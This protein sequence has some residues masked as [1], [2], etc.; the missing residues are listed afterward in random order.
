MLLVKFVHVYHSGR[1]LRCLHKKIKFWTF[2]WC[3]CGFLKKKKKKTCVYSNCQLNM[4]CIYWQTIL[5]SWKGG[6]FGHCPLK[7]RHCIWCQFLCLTL[8]QVQDNGA[9]WLSF[10]FFSPLKLGTSDYT[11]AW[12]TK[13]V[14]WITL[15]Q[16]QIN[17]QN[18]GL[19]MKPVKLERLKVL[20]NVFLVLH[21]SEL[22]NFL[23]KYI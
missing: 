21:P 1:L 16:F 5:H 12:K 7:A 17:L 22:P 18:Q 13:R 15:H 23:V 8:A 10:F 2:S 19:Y 4:Y 14:H 3:N 11:S 9:D 6:I 20:L